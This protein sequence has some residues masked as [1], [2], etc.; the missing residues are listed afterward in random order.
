MSTIS[1]LSIITF[2][3]DDCGPRS[4]VI[5]NVTVVNILLCG[6]F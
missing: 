4:F 1:K 5:K 3:V 6:H 2:T